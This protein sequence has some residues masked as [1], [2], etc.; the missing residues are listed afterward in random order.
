VWAEETLVGKSTTTSP[1]A[2]KSALRKKTVKDVTEKSPQRIMFAKESEVLAVPRIPSTEEWL[3]SQAPAEEMSPSYDVLKAS[4]KGIEP[5]RT[6]GK[7]TSELHKNLAIS[8]A[9]MHEID[10]STNPHKK[11]SSKG[12]MLWER[13]L[14]TDPAAK[15]TNSK[16]KKAVGNVRIVNRLASKKTSM[17]SAAAREKLPTHDALAIKP[18]PTAPLAPSEGPRVVKIRLRSSS[19]PTQ[20]VLTFVEEPKAPGAQGF[21]AKSR[22]KSVSVRQAR[23]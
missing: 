12:N 14:S 21:Q 1:S 16:F 13:T 15:R 20:S 10:F 18:V 2:L 19:T 6:E 23:P 11:T 5:T 8:E 22:I 9:K 17:F 4:Q 3:R 7:Y